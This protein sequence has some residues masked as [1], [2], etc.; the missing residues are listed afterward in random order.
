MNKKIFFGACFLLTAIIFS[1][2]VNA[3]VWRINNNA[4]VSRDFAQLST[5]VANASV[6]N[7]DTL[8][9]EASATAYNAVTFDKQLVVI[10]PGYFLTENTGLQANPNDVSIGSIILDSLASGSSFFGIHPGVLYTNS[11]TD[12]ITIS[13]CQLQL[14]Y[15][16]SIAN[17]KLSNWIINKCYLSQVNFAASSFIFENLQ[18]TN[19]FLTSSFT[20]AGTMINGLLR[21]NIFLN[22]VI[23]N[24]C[25][26]SNNIFLNGSTLTFTNC[27]VRY[28]I[29]QVNNLPA[30]NNNQNNITQASLFTLTGS[31]DGRYQ[32][33][34]GS[35]AS[36]A[37]E[38]ISGV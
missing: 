21:N 19:S 15:N 22:G 25:Y 11:N 6:V 18:L 27:T 14:F 24:N 34:M 10:G 7:G 4:G 5:A 16:T 23:A 20:I 2:S 29:S 12:N 8:Y 31:S 33:R 9:V 17:S 3:K 37:G 26:I 13:R 36:A 30:G 1:K 38:P 28:S 35:P 32:L